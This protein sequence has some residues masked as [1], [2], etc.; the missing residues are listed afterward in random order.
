MGMSKWIYPWNDSILKI[1]GYEYS[2]WVRY[3]FQTKLIVPSPRFELAA[4][5]TWS[6]HPF[7]PLLFLLYCLQIYSFRLLPK[8]SVL[9]FRFHSQ[10]SSERWWLYFWGTAEESM[11]KSVFDNVLGRI[12]SAVNK[13]VT[14]RHETFP[15]T[16]SHTTPHT[17]HV[18]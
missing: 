1:N 6:D 14:S 7:L 10:F 4:P 18:Q 11:D 13:L 16:P 9:V 12:L 17:Q 3:F 5:L 2:R 15:F 8:F